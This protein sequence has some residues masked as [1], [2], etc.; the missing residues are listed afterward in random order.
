[1]DFLTIATTAADAGDTVSTKIFYGVIAA[2]VSAVVGA[3]M[4]NQGRQI[5]RREEQ[6]RQ[7]G[8]VTIDSPVPE[9]TTREATRFAD[10]KQLDEHKSTTDTK[11]AEIAEDIDQIHTRLNAAFKVLN[12]LEG[13]VGGIKDNVGLLLDRAMGLPPGTT[14]TRQRKSS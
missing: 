6:Q 7:Q 4:R 2:I 3:I 8:N 9:I 14:V 5:G 1:M 11:F 13:T 10:S 12:T